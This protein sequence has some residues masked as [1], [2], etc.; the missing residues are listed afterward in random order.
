MKIKM[1][2]FFLIICSVFSISTMRS[3]EAANYNFQIDNFQIL[4]NLPGS[5]MDDFNYNTLAPDWEIQDG[6]PF[7]S[8][9]FVYLQSPGELMETL[10]LNGY[11]ILEE[12]SAISSTH[13]S[14]F[15]V[16]DGEGDFSASAKWNAV[17]PDENQFYGIQLWSPGEESISLNIFN[18]GSNLADALGIGTTPG[19]KIL[20]S[21]DSGLQ[22]YDISAV[23]VVDSIIL[24]LSFDDTN[25]LISPF[26]SLDNGS[27]TQT[28]FVSVDTRLGDF[29]E[30]VWM[31][32]GASLD[33]QVVPV[34]GTLWLFASGLFSLAWLRR[35]LTKISA[36]FNPNASLYKVILR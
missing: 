32:D 6:T 15:T 5:A 18:V 17:I 33:V 11:R 36:L 12:R 9:N 34:P 22:V 27:T 35:K 19:L 16:W 10:V 1:S 8:G 21:D 25:N 23:D 24:G 29:S 14:K 7:E 20:L 13:P 26:F 28:P 30:T 4:G 3:S 2:A 31:L